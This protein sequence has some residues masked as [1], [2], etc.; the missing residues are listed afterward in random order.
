MS[1]HR[2]W[3]KLDPSNGTDNAK[4]QDS[5]SAAAPAQNS[6][7]PAESSSPGGPEGSPDR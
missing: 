4:P 2:Q 1:D 5:Q 7:E 6:A 3:V